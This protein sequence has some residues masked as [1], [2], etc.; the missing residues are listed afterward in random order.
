MPTLKLAIGPN[1]GELAKALTEAAGL[2]VLAATVERFPDGEQRV[3]I[4]G[5]LHDV[6]LSRRPVR[7]AAYDAVTQ[8]LRGYA[9][10]GIRR[11]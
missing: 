11:V 7:A 10:G 8:W 6:F 5:A 4:D 9:P 3:R 2:P 1:N